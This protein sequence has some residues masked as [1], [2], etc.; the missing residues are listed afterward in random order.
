[1]KSRHHCSS[2]RRVHG[3]TLVELLVVIGIVAILAALIFPAISKARFNAKVVQCSNNY[4]QWA[5]A[6]A[7]YASDD[8]KGRLPSFPLPVDAMQG[9]SSI[10]PWF[11]SYGMVTNM[12][13]H[14][15]VLSMW[16]CPLRPQR[17]EVHQNNFRMKYGRE[18]VTPADMV[19]EWL[20]IQ[21]GA[22]V[23]PDLNWWVPR[24]LGDSKLE[25][26][27]PNLMI[28][29]TSEPWPRRMDDPTVATQPII[30]DWIVGEWDESSRSAIFGGGSGG[31]VRGSEMVNINAGF[32]DG[33]VETRP[34]SRLQWQARP[35][36]GYHVYIY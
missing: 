3:F 21:H 24:R 10:E 30:S 31:H 36:H 29:R 2:R 32:A 28:S 17:F 22:F 5:I 19:E 8:G 20:H 34:A 27:D 11:V 23:G 12:A 15:V 4:R 18:M 33:H 6:V 14:G 1:M 35:G 26:P 25:F 7:T 9:Y 13:T 16:F